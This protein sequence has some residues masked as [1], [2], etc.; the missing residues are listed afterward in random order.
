MQQLPPG[1]KVISTPQA[2]QQGGTIYSGV[3]TNKQQQMEIAAQTGERNERQ[4]SR[5]ARSDAQTAQLTEINIREKLQA[6]EAKD[7]DAQALKIGM[8]NSAEAVART[9]TILKALKTDATDNTTSPGLGETGSSGNFMRGIPM[10]SNAGKD[11]EAKVGTV[12]G[13]N[14]FSALKDL[15]AQGVKLTPISNA[16]IELAAS[17][18]ANIDPTISQKEFLGQVDQAIAFHQGAYNKIMKGLNDGKSGADVLTEALKSGKSKEEILQ[19][20]DLYNLDVNEED[21]D[22]NIASRAAGGTT[23]KVLPPDIDAI[24]QKY[25]GQ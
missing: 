22:L 8:S 7:A 19:M 24:M 2:Q 16:E 15:A 1:F 12:K 25:G 6:S 14:A 9:I 18:V 20:A 17:S 23:S 11:L 10:F 13:V 4:D 3:D 5:D 21:L